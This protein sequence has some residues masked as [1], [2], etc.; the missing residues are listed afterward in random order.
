MDGRV[1]PQIVYTQHPRA[2]GHLM[3]KTPQGRADTSIDKW[4]VSHALKDTTPVRHCA[5]TTPKRCA[6]VRALDWSLPG[7]KCLGKA[8]GRDW[9]LPP[10]S[11]PTKTRI[12]IRTYYEKSPWP[13][14]PK[15]PKL[16]RTLTDALN[17]IHPPRPV[18]S[19]TAGLATPK[20]H[21]DRVPGCS[22]QTRK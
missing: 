5:R 21:I 12:L 17:Y 4:V 11:P 15:I 6:A 20:L 1:L 13:L 18:Q 3:M 22:K 10:Q 2:P 16:I 14:G 7:V 8:N 19:A 9:H